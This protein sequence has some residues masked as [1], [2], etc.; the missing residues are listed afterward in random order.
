MTSESQTTAP[1]IL[2]T[3]RKDGTLVIAVWNLVDPDKQGSPR[4]VTVHLEGMEPASRVLLSRVDDDHGNTLG[5]YKKMGSPR[6]PTQ[7]QIKEL[8]QVVDS[9]RAE[10]VTLKNGAI[11]L[12]LP[13]NGL[14]LLE[15]GK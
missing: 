11:E 6:Y 10:N 4:K 5:A 14:Y 13:V 15:V 2:V 12:V 9:N 8:N 1:D 7:A 3:R